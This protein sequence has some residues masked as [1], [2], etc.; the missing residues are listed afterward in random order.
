MTESNLINP[1]ANAASKK[2]SPGLCSPFG[3]V[4]DRAQVSSLLLCVHLAL[5]GGRSRCKLSALLV[6]P[7][8]LPLFSSLLFTNPASLAALGVYKLKVCLAW[9]PF[10]IL[11]LLILTSTQHLWTISIFNNTNFRNPSKMEGPLSMVSSR[12]SAMRL[13]RSRA[14]NPSIRDYSFCPCQETRPSS[15][16]MTSTIHPTSTRFVP[17]CKAINLLLSKQ[18]RLPSGVSHQIILPG[19][20]AV[21]AG[22]GSDLR[23]WRRRLQMQA[24]LHQPGSVL[25]MLGKAAP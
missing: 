13:F 23:D 6:S 1:S 4:C 11:A 24:Q 8:S 21:W 14:T 22:V 5:K 3:A 16:V 9:W 7:S 25:L 18:K 20:S 10:S 2:L 17:C 15:W 19:S 12:T